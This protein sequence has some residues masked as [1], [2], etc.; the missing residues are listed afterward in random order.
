[1][2]VWGRTQAWLSVGALV[3]ASVVAAVLSE[4]STSGQLSFAALPPSF[5]PGLVRMVERLDQQVGAVQRIDVTESTNERAVRYIGR[6]SWSVNPP[7]GRR[8]WVAEFVGRIV[9]NA[10]FAVIPSNYEGPETVSHPAAA[11]IFPVG[12]TPGSASPSEFSYLTSWA[13]LS[14]LGPVTVLT[15]RHPH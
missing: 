11:Y 1:M 12:D 13:D 3:V 2:S 4:Q 7:S 15:D 5:T 9:W 10:A 6:G 8:V 14:R